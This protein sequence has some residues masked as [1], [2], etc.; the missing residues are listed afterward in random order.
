MLDVM[1]P[2]EENNWRISRLRIIQLYESDT[3]QS[4]RLVFARKMGYILEDSDL[5]PEMQFGSRPGK[6]SISPVVQKVLT[7]DIARLAKMVIGCEEND[8]ISCYDRISNT[9]GYLQCKGLGMPHNAI[10]ALADTWSNMVHVIRTAYGRSDSVYKSTPLVPLYGAGQGSTNG[11]FFWLLMFIIML[12]SV[13]PALRAL[14]FISACATLTASRVGDA[15]V[16]DSHVG[17]TSSYLDDP[18]LNMEDNTRL[19]ELQV[20][21][22]L[23]K[24]AQHYER[25]LWMTGGALNILKCSWVLIS[26]VWKNGRAR[27]ATIRESPAKLILTSG[28]ESTGQEVPRLEPS[29]VYRTLGVYITAG[30]AQPRGHATF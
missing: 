10:K 2:K 26:W 27:P 22:D 28:A 1:L 16:D 9:L 8:A 4:M 19:H 18:Y 25:L 29:K 11:P 15:F 20:V 21:Q 3:N 5:V 13:D 6:M 30:T 12:D 14:L 7:Y 17:A 23:T 24:L